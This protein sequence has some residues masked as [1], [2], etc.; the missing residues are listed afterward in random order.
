MTADM[1]THPAPFITYKVTWGIHV[2]IL[3]GLIVL[4]FLTGCAMNKPPLQ[5]DECYPTAWPDITTLETDCQGLNGTY[6][7]E[8]IY[9]DEKGT[10][11][12]LLTS[13]LPPNRHAKAESVS[14]NVVTNKIDANADS[15]ATLQLVFDNSMMSHDSFC[16]QRTLFYTPRSSS[17]V[18]PFIAIIGSQQNVW[19]T[20]A[21]DGSLLANVWD[22]TAGVVILFP[23]Y[24]QSHYWARFERIGDLIPKQAE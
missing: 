1:N 23:F 6:A 10:H 18:V 16:I 4:L 21:S 5:R 8:G 24:I 20:K 3:I 15:F 19:L 22:Y 13:I 17:G 2:M 12:I 14:L 9:V 7:N 11:S